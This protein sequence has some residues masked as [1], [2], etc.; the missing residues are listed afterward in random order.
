M[1][2]RFNAQNALSISAIVLGMVVLAKLDLSGVAHAQNSRG[3]R[4]T[5]P[6]TTPQNIPFNATAQ[7]KLI[8]EELRRLDVR[9]ST[10]EQKLEAGL[11]V[12][13]TEMPSVRIE[14]LPEND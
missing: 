8:I 13:V 2:T 11:N 14:N 3:S 7:R 4:G 10:I 9:M 6:T 1:R 12:R 5:P